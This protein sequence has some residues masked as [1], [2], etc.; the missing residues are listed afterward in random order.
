MSFPF[1]PGQKGLGPGWRQRQLNKGPSVS[2]KALKILS[3]CRQAHSCTRPRAFC[4]L[5]GPSVTHK[6]KCVPR[7][8]WCQAAH[9][10][11]L[12]ASA[13]SPTL[14]P[15]GLSNRHTWGQGDQEGP[16]AVHAGCTLPTVLLHPHTGQQGQQPPLLAGGFLP[17]RQPHFIGDPRFEERDSLLAVE[18]PTQIEVAPWALGK[19]L[20]QALE[21]SLLLLK[22]K[23]GKGGS[24]PVLRE[25][26]GCWGKRSHSPRSPSDLMEKAQLLPWG[27]PRLMKEAV[28]QRQVATQGP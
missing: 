13:L 6:D 27:V 19:P 3:R 1:S 14:T 24:N 8:A 17:Q 15:P 9:M 11:Q 10:V 23:C 4:C 25:I 28:S 2:V 12:V 20:V 16:R 22:A 21:P 18:A 26:P 5:N 7:E